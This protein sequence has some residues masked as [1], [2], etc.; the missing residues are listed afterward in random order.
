MIPGKHREIMAQCDDCIGSLGQN[1][2]DTEKRT[3]KLTS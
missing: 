3:L 1:F 2:G